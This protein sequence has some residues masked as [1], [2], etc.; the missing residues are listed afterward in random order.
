[1]PA[2][3]AALRVLDGVLRRGEALEA[4]LGPAAR[5]LP[6]N[7]RALAHALA[8]SVL[9]WMVDLDALIDSA[10]RLRLADDA[11]AR[12]ALRLALAQALV[13]G[14]PGHAA[15]S[16]VLPLVDGGPRKL[17][18]GVFGTLDRRGATLPDIPSLPAEVADRWA[19]AWGDTVARAAARALAAPPPLDLTLADPADAEPMAQRL[20]GVSLLPGHVRLADHDAVPDIDGYG[21]GRWWVQ[22]LAASL[23][24]RLIGGGDG[25]AIDVCA[26]PGGKTMQLAAAGWQV[27]AI[28]ASESRLARL[29]DN[30]ART[31]LAASLVAADALV[32]SPP[33]QADVV[34][35]D[36]PCSATGIFRRHPDVLYRAHPRLIAETVEA[37]ARLLDRVAG[38]V[39][40]GG[41]LVYAVC[42]LEPEEGEEQLARFLARDGRFAIDPVLPDELPAGIPTS[43]QGWLRTLPGQLAD[44]GGCDGFFAA[45]MIRTG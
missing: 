38:W 5:G 42:S 25:R 16:T 22:D 19:L 3:R 36:A 24:A 30:L 29:S 26:A 1:V 14:T 15:I 33:V 9:R 6:A 10:T 21:A 41:I 44:A 45:R 37:Q 13:L 27:T 12:M 43:R 28:D 23:P 18:H 32:W 2:R 34:L 31:G 40:P 11:K 17:V 20:H 7:D 39:R 8:A 4:A 35:L